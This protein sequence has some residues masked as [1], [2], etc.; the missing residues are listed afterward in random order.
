M[1]SDLR[2]LIVEDSQTQAM[3]LKSLLEF[4]D[5]TVQMVENGK[6]ALSVIKQFAP[7]IV[8]S[9]VIM[10]EMDGYELCSAIK[11]NPEL[12]HIPVILV[13]E[14]S[15]PRDVVKGLSSGADNFIIKPYDELYLLN[16]VR[17]F[18]VNLALRESDKVQ[19]GLEIQLDGERHVITSARQQI[20]DLLISTYEQGI[21]LNHEL[22]HKRDALAKSNSLLNSLFHFSKSISESSEELALVQSGLSH[23]TTFPGLRGCWLVLRNLHHEQ[24]TPIVVGQSGAVPDNVSSCAQS[25]LARDVWSKNEFESNLHV[26]Q[27][28]ALLHTSTKGHLTIPLKLGCE[29]IGYLA[30]LC[31]SNN[32]D[33][34]LFESLSS[35]ARQLATAIGKARLMNS[36]ESLVTAKTRAIKGQE[37]LLANILNTLPVGVF[38]ADKTGKLI[39]HNPKGEQIWGGT[40]ASSSIKEYDA[41]QGWWAESGKKV[42][43]EEWAM[44]RALTHGETTLN[45]RIK[46]Q[47]FDGKTKYINNSGLPL[48]DEH[49]NTVG[50]LV[51]AE[52]ITEQ[53]KLNQILQ[54]RERALEHSTTG[55]II[56]DHQALDEPIVYVN[57]SFERI[58]GFKM[59]EIVGKNC[60]FLQRGADCQEGLALIRR[61]LINNEPCEVVLNNVRKDGSVFINE[62]RLAPVYNANKEVTHYIGSVND[63]TERIRYQR[64]LEDRSMYDELTGLINR[65][66]FSDRIT[67]ALEACDGVNSLVAIAFINICEFKFFN[68]TH[69]HGFGDKVLRKLANHLSDHIKP[70]YSCSRFSGDTFSVLMPKIK[71]SELIYPEVKTLQE[72]CTIALTVDEIMISLQ[73]TIGFTIAPFD[74]DSAD[75]LLR[76]ADTALYETK[77][78]N[79]GGVGAYT[80]EMNQKVQKRLSFD[81]DIRAAIENNE[82]ELYYQP[83]INLKSGK[84]F[85]FESLIRWRKNNSLIMPF[86]FIPLA[87]QTGIIA[88]IDRWVVQHGVLT[89]ANWISAGFNAT[90][91]SINLSSASFKS[92]AIVDFIE[93]ELRARNVPSYLLEVEITEGILIGDKVLAHK[94]MSALRN[95][96]VRLSLDDFGTGFASM[97]YLQS[98][99]F[100]QIKI[101]KSFVDGIHTISEN[102][103]LSRSVIYIAH[104]L[105][106]DVIAEGVETHEQAS[107]LALN[108]CDEVQGYL[109]SKAVPYEATLSLLKRCIIFRLPDLDTE[110]ISRTILVFS[111]RHEVLQ[112]LRKELRLS[113]Y[114]M[115]LIRHEDDIFLEMAKHCTSTLIIDINTY[116]QTVSQLLSRLRAIH[117]RTMRIVVC[118]QASEIRA[119]EFVESGLVNRYLTIPFDPPLLRHNL[120]EASF[121]FKVSVENEKIRRQFESKPHS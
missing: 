72:L 65:N 118:D 5:I 90:R 79:K 25:C 104:T 13:T 102:A 71:T 4:N 29:C 55:V 18:M 33:S 113:N 120:K 100:N 107:Y 30:V 121:L 40:Y 42:L 75:Q 21:R 50:G 81:G 78:T 67:Q 34:E 97:S 91:L 63:I 64:E 114:V 10:P 94:I 46:I 54:L 87:E 8:I 93:S 1:Y 76:N 77:H 31:S 36:L 37:R 16:R 32:A 7:S 47:T 98:F 61:A 45:Q 38:V 88:E 19:L 60:R 99:P 59:Q 6:H 35:A 39:M 101:D 89:L 119:R 103:T 58:T 11:K 26:E 95:L 85:G 73:V 106:M 49:Q 56:T 44:A 28:P 117:P 3:N 109:F 24:E 41:Y 108:D 105:S 70:L 92:E 20:L 57:K 48:F 69:G 17:Y 53:I 116:P 23:I 43:P 22:R 14:L 66:I 111:R 74:G 12:S 86:E 27:C 62:L 83:Q 15:D 112:S 80:L 115:K 96:G 110:L 9:D 52:D 2:V 82:L 51:V 84:I 68:E